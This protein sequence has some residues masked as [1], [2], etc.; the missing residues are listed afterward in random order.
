MFNFNIKNTENINSNLIVLMNGSFVD[1]TTIFALCI[2]N[3]NKKEE[4]A[5]PQEIPTQ[6]RID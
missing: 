6:N 1:C 5:Y 3:K 2:I 4:Y